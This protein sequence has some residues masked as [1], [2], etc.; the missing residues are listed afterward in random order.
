[1]IPGQQADPAMP[2]GS[3]VSTQNAQQ[4]PTDGVPITAQSP[5]QMG[6]KGGGFNLLYLAKRAA[7]AIKKMD[8]NQGMIELNKM[9]MQNPQLGNLVWQILQ[10][11][12]GSQSDPLDPMQSPQ[13]LLKPSRRAASTGA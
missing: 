8:P 3:T 9:K 7:N 6:Q 10:R 1:M 4:A 13:P 5:L 2:E 11:E 12:K